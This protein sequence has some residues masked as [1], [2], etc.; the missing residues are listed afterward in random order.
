MKKGKKITKAVS[1]CLFLPLIISTYMSEV[2]QHD[3]RL[4]EPQVMFF[5]MTDE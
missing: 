3:S 2:H 5:C 4:T 1:H